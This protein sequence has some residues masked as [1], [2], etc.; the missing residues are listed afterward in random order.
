MVFA[1]VSAAGSLLALAVLSWMPG[2]YLV[3]TGVLS[4][5]QEHFLAYF[6]SGCTV[7]LATRGFSQFQIACALWCYAGVLELGQL[8]VPGRHAAFVDFSASALGA[9]VGIGTIAVLRRARSARPKTL[10]LSGGSPSHRAD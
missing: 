7:G 10:F 2:P 9:L 5:Q 3:R 4:G 6:L 1:R 8:A